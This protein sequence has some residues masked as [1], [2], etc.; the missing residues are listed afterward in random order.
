MNTGF[1]GGPKDKQL[2]NLTV[3]GNDVLKDI[4]SY[5]EQRQGF[6]TSLDEPKKIIY[7]KT[8]LK[9]KGEFK[10]FYVFN[11]ID[12]A[13]LKSSIADYWSLSD[14]IGYDLD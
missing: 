11:G 4:Y 5:S 1:I 3:Y 9:H 10:H 13:T 7:I 12:A 8:L 14:T 6:Q 2:Y